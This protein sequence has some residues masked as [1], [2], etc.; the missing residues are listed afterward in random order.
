M[1]G[2]KKDARKLEPSAQEDLRRRVVAAVMGGM[3]QNL[4]AE[5]FGIAR[6]TVWQW[7]VAYR[8]GG[9]K[10]LAARKRGPKGE[11]GKL[12][13]WQAATI[14]NLIRDRHPEQMK[15]PFVLWTSEAVRGLIKRKFGV[16][17]SARSVRRYL[18]RWGFTPQKPKRVA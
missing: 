14:C 9:E 4:A 7:M 16:E 3:K 15:L 11:C 6:K 1:M 10:A 8:S 18:R 17:P 5:A 12:L 2:M 13:G